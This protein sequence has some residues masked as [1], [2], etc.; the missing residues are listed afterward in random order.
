ML[1]PEMSS[2]AESSLY[3]DIQNMYATY[4]DPEGPE[5]LHLPGDISMGICQSKN[6]SFWEFTCNTCA[7]YIYILWT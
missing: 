5:Y 1:N 2:N 6:T 3:T 7:I 4:L